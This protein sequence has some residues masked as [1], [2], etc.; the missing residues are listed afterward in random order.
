MS[1]GQNC[2]HVHIEAENFSDAIALPPGYGLKTKIHK[3]IIIY[4]LH[5]SPM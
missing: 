5:S 2:P 1:V 3:L 4:F